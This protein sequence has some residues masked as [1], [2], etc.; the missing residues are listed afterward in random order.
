[1]H[2]HRLTFERNAGVPSR[3]LKWENEKEKLESAIPVLSFF[4]AKGL[5][6]R[7][8]GTPSRR[9]NPLRWGN[10]PVHIISHFNLITLT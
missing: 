5:C 9:G 10:M 1:M 7:R 8:W 3:G 4:Q 6:T 2:V